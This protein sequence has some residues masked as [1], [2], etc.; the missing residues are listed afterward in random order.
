MGMPEI[1]GVVLDN[2]IQSQNQDYLPS[3]LLLQREITN[4][5]I[6]KLIDRYSENMIGIFS[7]CQN[8][9]ND[10]VT[11]TKLKQSLLDFLYRCNLSKKK[12][13]SLALFQADQALQLSELS[14]KKLLIF[15]C[16]PVDEFG[17]TLI[18]ITNIA[19][20][21][22]D[23]KIVCF[24]DA[25]PF[26]KMVTSEVQLPNVNVLLVEPN[27]NFEDVVYDFLI[28]DYQEEDPEFLEAL[29]KSK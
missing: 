27:V 8:V 22:V 1:V 4:S 3:R 5:I 25:L 19:F 12:N 28:N 15:M 2:G 26:G 13:H 10:I 21:G 29:E 7:L 6:N 17:K 16:S 9:P 18:E 23:V 24:G 20:K 11:P 14:T